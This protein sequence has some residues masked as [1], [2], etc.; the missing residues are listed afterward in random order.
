MVK[1]TYQMTM[2]L[3]YIP[4]NL[5]PIC[6]S[7]KSLFELTNEM[8]VAA[9]NHVNNNIIMTIFKVVD[10]VLSTNQMPGAVRN[11]V[12]LIFSQSNGSTNAKPPGLQCWL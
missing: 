10:L 1:K 2:G 11:R 3:L 6:T 12:D 4:L 7:A 9:Q 8:P 5:R